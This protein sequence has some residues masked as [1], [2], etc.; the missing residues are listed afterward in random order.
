MVLV[1][2]MGKSLNACRCF[3]DVTQCRWHACQVSLDAHSSLW[4]CSR[5]LR[6]SGL[7][8]FGMR[9]NCRYCTTGTNFKLKQVSIVPMR[10]ETCESHFQVIVCGGQLADGTVLDKAWACDETCWHE[11]SAD[12]P[13]KA[14]MNSPVP[15][16]T[17]KRTSRHTGKHNGSAPAHPPL[18]S[19]HPSLGQVGT[20]GRAR[21]AAQLVHMCGRRIH[22]PQDMVTWPQH[23]KGQIKSQNVNFIELDCCAKGGDAGH[24]HRDLGAPG[25][26]QS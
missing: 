5:G 25:R 19:L 16:P 23:T 14:S 8:A 21:N 4:L 24:A 11:L 2:K 13:M 15:A 1:G 12:Y 7:M 9:G 26:A 10:L 20:H 3:G 22:L 18:S 17:L 6:R